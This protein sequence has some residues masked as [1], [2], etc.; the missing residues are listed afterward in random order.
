[1]AF[2]AKAMLACSMLNDRKI[3]LVLY[4]AFRA[5]A[6]LAYMYFSRRLFQF[7]KRSASYLMR[8]MEETK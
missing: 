3:Q 1:M 6:M 2:R 7:D 5:K 8:L 4:L